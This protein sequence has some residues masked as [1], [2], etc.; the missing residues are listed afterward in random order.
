MAPVS[1][2]EEKRRRKK[3][4]LFSLPFNLGKGG[5]A[6]SGTDP[7]RERDPPPP[8]FLSMQ[9]SSAVPFPPLFCVRETKVQR[10][11]KE[12]ARKEV[13]VELLKLKSE[14]QQKKH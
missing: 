6:T 10:W 7:W 5:V 12:E 3:K 11:K 13:V 14:P 4:R 8:P 2:W 9:A 1:K